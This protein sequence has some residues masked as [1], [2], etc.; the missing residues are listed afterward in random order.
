MGLPGLRCASRTLA[1]VLI[2]SCR[3]AEE[4]DEFRALEALFDAAAVDMEDRGGT[5]LGVCGSRCGLRGGRGYQLGGRSSANTQCGESVRWQL[6]EGLP[7]AEA[8]WR[9]AEV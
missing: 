6:D 2:F 8:N 5:R 9:M 1:V 7:G 3:P 4:A